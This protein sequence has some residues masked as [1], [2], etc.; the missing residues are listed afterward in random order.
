MT[1][2]LQSHRL[3]GPRGPSSRLLPW[4]F[5]LLP[6]LTAGCDQ[7][8]AQRGLYYWGAEVNVVCPCGVGGERGAAGTGQRCFW[9]RGDPALLETMQVYVQRNISEP[10]Q[11]VFLSY[12]GEFLDEPTVGFAA[13]YEGYQTV[14]EVLS[15]SVDLPED[16]PPP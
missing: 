6:A 9:V 1:G 13:N 3:P 2:R 11:P 5:V 8:P 12:R 15:V 14:T 10:Y 4:S 7:P 16:C